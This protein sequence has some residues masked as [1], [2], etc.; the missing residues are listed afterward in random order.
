MYHRETLLPGMEGRGPAILTSGQSTVV[1]TPHYRFRIDGVGTLI[2]NRLIK[3]EQNY[4]AERSAVE[5][6]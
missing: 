2:A 1:I 5:K 3:T 4:L 6:R